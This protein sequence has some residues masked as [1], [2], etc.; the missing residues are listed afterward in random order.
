MHSPFRRQSPCSRRPLT[1]LRRPRLP[2]ARLLA[3]LLGLLMVPLLIAAPA[4][5]QSEATT[6]AQLTVDIWPEYDE[7][8]VL[9]LLTITRSPDAGQETVVIP[10]PDAAEL[11]AVARVSEEGAFLTDGIETDEGRSGQLAV[12]T[13]APRLRI[14]YY[15]PYEAEGDGRRFGFAWTSDLLVEQLVVTVQQPM[16]SSDFAVFPEPFEVFRGQD[17]LQ[18]HTLPATAVAP[19]VAFSVQASYT[20]PGGQLTADLLAGQQAQ[21][22]SSNLAPAATTAEG[23]NWLLALAG[24]GIV[25]ILGALA[26]FVLGNRPGRARPKARKPLPQSQPSSAKAGAGPRARFCHQCGRPAEPGD[27]F[28]SHCGTALKRS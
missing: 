12:T 18:Y 28:C 2:S 16:N 14:E 11:H 10:L 15:A 5:A 8:S 7:P 24:G 19:G 26:Y 9:V 21:V 20:N 3:G 4:A 1:R 25:L 23:F 27:K 6:L 13:A 17:G 22:A